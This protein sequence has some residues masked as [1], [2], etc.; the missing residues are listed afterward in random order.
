MHFVGNQTY[1]WEDIFFRLQT[2]TC[3]MILCSI[4]HENVC[5]L[6]SR[7]Y[8]NFGGIVMVVFW[9]MVMFSVAAGVSEYNVATVCRVGGCVFLPNIVSPSVFPAT[10]HPIQDGCSIHVSHS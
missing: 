4:F 1:L 3:R 8:G 9:D 7:K 5:V 6:W 10:W 2:V